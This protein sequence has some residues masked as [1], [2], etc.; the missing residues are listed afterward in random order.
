MQPGNY[1][2]QVNC[3][4]NSTSYNTGTSGIFNLT[5]ISNLAPIVTSVFIESQIDLAPG[6]A[7]LVFCNASVTD[8]NN[9]SDISKVNATLYD[10]SVGSA[11][12][13]DKNDHY[14]NESCKIMAWSN[15][16]ANYSCSF[17]LEYFANNA[18]WACNIT[19]T[20]SMNSTGSANK[21]TRISDMVAIDISPSVIDYG[22]LEGT[23]TSNDINVTITNF[24]NIAINA[25]V[26]GFGVYQGDS[27]AMNCTTGNIPVGNQRYS[28]IYNTVYGSMT[29][30]TSSQ[31]PIANITLQQ[32]TDD[33][34]YASD[35]NN[36]YWKLQMPL[37]TQGTCNGTIIFNAVIT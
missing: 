21:S 10:I 3:T 23:Q 6:S 28:Q 15:Y 18:S 12:P 9:I 29:S 22:S 8:E 30:L 13:D 5:L 31:T 37:S 17:E 32:R 19:A 2:W 33:F 25:T 4:D 20:D 1:T 36:T 16:Q 11:S 35:R 26:M 27:L 14:T 7:I 24:G 34:S